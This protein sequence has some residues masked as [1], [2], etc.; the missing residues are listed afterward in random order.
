[1]FVRRFLFVCL[2]VLL[3]LFLFCVCFFKVVS[4][5]YVSSQQ[6]PTSK[7]AEAHAFS[8]LLIKKKR[9]KSDSNCIGDDDDATEGKQ[10]LTDHQILIE[11][12]SASWPAT[13]TLPRGV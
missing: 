11:N 5:T 8:P 6:H 1:M 7:S 13:A 3:F 9:A 12:V 10:D 2:F 4:I